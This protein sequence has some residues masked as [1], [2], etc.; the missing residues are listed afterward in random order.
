[1]LVREQA[2]LGYMILLASD[3]QKPTAKERSMLPNPLPYGQVIM[4]RKDTCL[5]FRTSTLSWTWSVTRKPSS[6]QRFQAATAARFEKPGLSV[7]RTAE[8]VFRTSFLLLWCRRAAVKE[9]L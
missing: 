9:V 3:S 1:M 6:M 7:S 8:G 5:F 4:K 2:R